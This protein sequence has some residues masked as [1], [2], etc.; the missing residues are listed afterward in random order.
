MIRKPLP[1]TGFTFQ[2]PTISVPDTWTAD[3][4]YDNASA[5]IIR[6]FGEDQ[7]VERKPARHDPRQL[8][9]YFS[10]YANRAPHGGVIFVGVADNGDI[11]GCAQLD[12]KRLDEL[13]QTGRTY[14]PDAR[15]DSKRVVVYNIAGKADFVLAIRVAYRSD[16]LVETTRGDAY[17]RIGSSKKKLSELEK[18]E[19]RI[20]K[21]E[22]DFES[23]D[24]P[25]AWPEAFDRELID[26]FSTSFKSR[27]GLS[28][29]LSQVELLALAHLGRNTKAGFVPNVAC[30]LLFA[31]DPRKVFPGS[32]IRLLRFD[33]EHELTGAQRNEVFDQWIDGPIPHII[34]AAEQ[35]ISEQLSLNKGPTRL[36]GGR[37][38]SDP[39][40]KDA[41]RE[42]IVNAC[43]HRSYNFRNMSTFVRIFDDHITVESPGGFPPPT[44]ART[45][46]DTHNPRNPFLM[47]AL[48]YLDFVKCAHEGARRIRDLMSESGLP[49]PEYSEVDLDGYLVRLTLR[50]GNRARGS[51]QPPDSVGGKVTNEKEEHLIAHIGTTAS[52]SVSEAERLLQVGWRTAK[53][54]LDGLVEKEILERRSKSD[55]PKDPTARYFRRTK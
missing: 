50:K 10:I 15:Y 48:F 51:V 7:R 24:V 19:I 22:I 36:S 39:Y 31:T 38:T 13:E 42:A 40:P 54:I 27:R 8:G 35:A 47:E 2:P 34:A 45:V 20:A 25:L 5:D 43:V 12:K 3:D 29:H 16:K 52:V 23:E 18:R 9:D 37:F 41:W 1:Q 14:C 32:R 6:Q 28:S 44:T 21:R 55:K 26:Q 17:T 11:E 33:G 4:I 53:K 49:A 46:Y 30:A